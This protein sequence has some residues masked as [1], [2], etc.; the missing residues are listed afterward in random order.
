M[1]IHPFAHPTENGVGVLQSWIDETKRFMAAQGDG[2]ELWLTETGWSSGRSL[3]GHSTISEEQQADW[4]GAIYRDVVG[5]QKIFW[6]NFKEDRANPT[7]PEAQWGWLRYDLTP[8]PAFK[9]FSD[10]RRL[11]VTD[12]TLPPRS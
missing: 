8:K 1:A 5:P 7:D 10:L 12:A 9:A 4:V 3:W 11:G 6:Y 2:R